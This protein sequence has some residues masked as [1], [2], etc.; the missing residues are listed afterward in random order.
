MQTEIKTI[1]IKI[2][3]EAGFGIKVAGATLGKVFSR[4]G[5]DVFDYT[6]YPSLIRG[7]HN[8]FEITIGEKVSHHVRPVNLLVALNQQT[9][10]DHLRELSDDAGVIFDPVKVTPNS[11]NLR[12]FGVPFTQITKEVGGSDLMKNTVALGAVLAVLGGNV[13]GL[14]DLIRSTF[15]KKSESII[16]SNINAARGGYDFIKNNC[17]NF[18]NVIK[19]SS[20]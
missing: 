19:D 15:A 17:A 5:Y 16:G 18:S 14:L 2:G 8:T 4:L 6:E 9:F 10:N 20:A 12:Q 13:E 3:G 11:K 1:T 7:G